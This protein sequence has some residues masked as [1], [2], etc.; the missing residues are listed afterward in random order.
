[1]E[2]VIKVNDM[3]LQGKFI[4]DNR[5]VWYLFPTE[6]IMKAQSLRVRINKGL[7]VWVLTL[8]NGEKWFYEPFSHEIC[9]AENIRFG[10]IFFGRFARYL[11]DEYEHKNCLKK[12][13]SVYLCT[14]KTMFLFKETKEYWP[15]GLENDPDPKIREMAGGFYSKTKTFSSFHSAPEAEELTKNDEY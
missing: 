10:R 9:K 14:S 2:K 15:Q 5:I 1:M 13:Y 6:M 8:I 11:R 4:I 12:I 3:G 7:P